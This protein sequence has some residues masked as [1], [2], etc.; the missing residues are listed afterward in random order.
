[1]TSLPKRK[2][3]LAWRKI[4]DEVVIIDLDKGRQ[5]HELNDTGS[6]IWELCD[7]ETSVEAIATALTEDFELD[8]LEAQ[9]EVAEFIAFLAEKDLLS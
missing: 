1:M 5:F 4:E 7:G 2:Q 3:N 8:Y 6:L 9:N